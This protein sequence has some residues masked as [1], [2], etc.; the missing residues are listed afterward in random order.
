MERFGSGVVR[1]ADGG[2]MKNQE[3]RERRKTSWRGFR[4]RRSG[5]RFDPARQVQ[6]YCP[7]K[8]PGYFR[9]VND[10]PNREGW[11]E[12][13]GRERRSEGRRE[14]RVREGVGGEGLNTESEMDREG[15]RDVERERRERVGGRKGRVKGKGDGRGTSGRVREG[16][17][18]MLGGNGRVRV[19]LSPL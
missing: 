1:R 9:L 17:R 15:E 18:E 4:R 19:N 6:V 12:G 14:Y 3:Q 11:R 8:V 10:F 13:R 5:V 7:L 16:G 2:N